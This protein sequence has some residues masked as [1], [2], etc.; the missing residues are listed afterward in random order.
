MRKGLRK[1]AN[2]TLFGQESMRFMIKTD[3]IAKGLA[4]TQ[5]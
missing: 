4:G 5:A 1:S 3:D 2:E